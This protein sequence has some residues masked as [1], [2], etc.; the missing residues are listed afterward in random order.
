MNWTPAAIAPA[1]VGFN[2]ACQVERLLGDD[3]LG[4]FSV[5]LQRQAGRHWSA[6]SIGF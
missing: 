3:A 2:D 5:A 6:R 1:V 4:R